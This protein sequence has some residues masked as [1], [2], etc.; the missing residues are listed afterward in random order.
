MT[1]YIV[2]TESGRR[3]EIDHGDMFWRRLPKDGESAWVT[4]GLERIWT[5]QSGDVL[6]FP[7]NDPTD[8]FV[9]VELPVLGKFMFIA[10]RDVW[11]TST[12]VVSVEA[13]EG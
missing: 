9:D 10:S 7:W 5:L 11:W 8:S 12:R 2:T 13:Q 4:G 3:Y 6:A 1:K